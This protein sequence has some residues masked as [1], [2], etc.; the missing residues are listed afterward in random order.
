M[1]TLCALALIFIVFSFGWLIF[2]RY[3]LNTTPTWV[4]HVALLLIAMITFFMMAVNQRRDQNLAVGAITDRLPREVQKPVLILV[5]IMILMFGLIM[6]FY[7]TR[8]GFFNLG[9]RIPILGISEG[10][11]M[12]PPSVGG[13]VLAFFSAMNV[14]ERI[15]ADPISNINHSTKPKT[16]HATD[17][18]DNG[19]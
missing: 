15:F 5:D 10:V 7:S 3:I 11:R 13:A 17:Q 9:Q 2:G 6:M 14:L 18:K 19:Y 4:E 1:E 8:L 12:I 16:T